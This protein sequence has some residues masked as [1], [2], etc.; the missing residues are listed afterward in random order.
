MSR[1]IVI[2]GERGAGK[3]RY[4]LELLERCEKDKLSVGGFISPAVYEKGIK[5]AFYTMDVR[6]REQRCCGTRTAPD[7]GTVGCW[8]M[9]PLFLNGEMSCCG[10]AFP[11]TCCSLTSWGRWNLKKGKGIPKPF[12]C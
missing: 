3:S 10:T 4:C 9:D 8:Q 11:V 2:T 5:I 7:R 6:T 1:I 12:P